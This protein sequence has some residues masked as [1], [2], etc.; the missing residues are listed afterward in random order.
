M[1]SVITTFTA[2]SFLAF[3]S[4]SPLDTR[5]T[6]TCSPNLGGAS[7][8]IFKFPKEWSLGSSPPVAGDALVIR[9]YQLHNNEFRVEA[10]D[11]SDWNVLIKCVCKVI[12][13]HPIRE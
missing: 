5:S 1:F 3:V 11:R 7:L 6:T 8:S 2:F 9:H 10:T 12:L 4:A 13:I